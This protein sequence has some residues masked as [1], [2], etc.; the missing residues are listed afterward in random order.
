MDDSSFL[1]TKGEFYPGGIWERK[2]EESESHPSDPAARGDVEGVEKEMEEATDSEPAVKDRPLE[3]SESADSLEKLEPKRQFRTTMRSPIKEPIKPPSEQILKGRVS[4]SQS[5]TSVAS[6]PAV[7]GADFVNVTGISPSRD[8]SKRVAEAAARAIVNRQKMN[9]S[10]KLS[11]DGTPDLSVSRPV[12]L[13]SCS[14][15]D[16]EPAGNRELD[17]PVT[18]SVVAERPESAPPT[19][20]TKDDSVATQTRDVP[21]SPVRRQSSISSEKPAVFASRVSQATDAAKDMLKT[22]LNTYLAKRQQS[23]LQ[24]QI[25]S[26]DR[27]ELVNSIKPRTRRLPSEVS[28]DLDQKNESEDIDSGPLPFETKKSPLFAPSEF[29]ILSSPGYGPSAMMTI[30]STMANARSSNICAENPVGPSSSPALPPRPT[31]MKRPAP[32]PLPP[33]SA[34]RPIPRRPVP[35]PPLPPQGA[36]SSVPTSP[37]VQPRQFENTDDDDLMI[38]HIPSDDEEA[39]DSAGSSIKGISLSPVEAQPERRRVEQEEEAVLE[40]SS[41]GSAKSRR[42]SVAKESVLPQWSEKQ[43]QDTDMPE[44]ME[45]GLMG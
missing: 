24:K 1:P 31:S 38:L 15:L 14:S 26:N 4:R 17:D 5:F 20:E 34:P 21:D 37:E 23:K 36:D 7:V 11:T 19:L 32:P 12:S 3:H 45:Q 8:D 28:T 43:A 18:L 2:N 44:I 27:D 13:K 16:D 41:Y 42:P 9:E 39:L 22:R 10:P 6:A 30:P 29:S 35:E 33:R 40:P 25:L